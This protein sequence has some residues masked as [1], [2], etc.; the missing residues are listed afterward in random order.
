MKQNAILTLLLVLALFMFSGCSEKDS[1]GPDNPQPEAP[2]LADNFDLE[3]VLPD[4]L[5]Q[6]DS[7]DVDYEGVNTTGYSLAQFV[8]QS[9]VNQYL[10]VE[11]FDSRT[12]F[13]YEIVSSDDD[14]NWSPRLR[15]MPDLAWSQFSSGYI[16]PAE[17]AKAFFP[18]ELIAGTYNVKYATYFRLYRKIDTS[19]D[20]TSTTYETGAFPTTEITYIKNDET[21]VEQ[22]FPLTNLISD[23]VT[24]DQENYSYRFVAGDGWEN[25]DTDNIFSWEDLQNGYWLTE[26]DRA[27]FLN[28]DTTLKWKSV[29]YVESIQLAE[30]D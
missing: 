10:D 24:D 7:Q 19:L 6:Y 3:I 21:F 26:L 14:G 28:E 18:D 25:D 16:L 13:A 17:S 8:G 9:E 2:A 5:E 27:V 20:G 1:T 15:G 4:S 29:K 12:L 11:Q 30:I 23:Y 22:G